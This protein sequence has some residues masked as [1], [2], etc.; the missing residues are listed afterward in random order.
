MKQNH[1][2]LHRNKDNERKQT[3]RMGKFREEKPN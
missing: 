3:D 2:Y 1:K